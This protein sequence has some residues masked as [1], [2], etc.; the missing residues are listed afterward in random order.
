MLAKPKILKMLG[1]IASSFNSLEQRRQEDRSAFQGVGGAE[2]DKRNDLQNANK[3]LLEFTKT[4]ISLLKEELDIVRKKNEA[5]KTK[6]L[7]ERALGCTNR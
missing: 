2:A 3:S 7:S 6:W 5:E 1:L 4:R